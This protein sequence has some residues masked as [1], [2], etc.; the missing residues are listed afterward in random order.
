MLIPL[1]AAALLVSANRNTSV[2]VEMKPVLEGVQKERR[3]G[4][5]Q[6]ILLGEPPSFLRKPISGVVKYGTLRLDGDDFVVAV[7]MDQPEDWTIYLDSDRNGEFGDGERLVTNRAQTKAVGTDGKPFDMFTV[8][9]QTTLYRTQDDQRLAYPLT[10]AIAQPAPTSPAPKDTIIVVRDYMRAGKAKIGQRE[11]DLVLDDPAV[12][13]HFTLGGNAAADLE[14][15]IDLDGDGHFNP[16]FEKLP[17]DGAFHL[18]GSAYRVTSI[19]RSG[20]RLVLGGGDAAAATEN[21]PNFWGTAKGDTIAPFEAPLLDGKTLRFPDDV[22][23]KKVLFMTWS[24][25]RQDCPP[26]MRQL[27]AMQDR[28]ADTGLRVIGINL[29]GK[30]QRDAVKRVLPVTLPNAPHIFEGTGLSGPVA[31]RLGV[32]RAPAMLLVDG[33]TGRVIVPF[34]EAEWAKA[35]DWLAKALGLQTKGT[36]F[37]PSQK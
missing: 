2:T 35:N 30:E 20:T 15:L 19:N 22:K 21:S 18:D 17:L 34:H 36:G 1:L 3:Q 14:L 25:L 4:K 6:G 7:S 37:P 13:G 26:I 8:V 33:D 5:P 27:S 23:G 28:L 24:S 29:D 16:F 32:T 31:R 10:L 11:Y 12:N 9:A